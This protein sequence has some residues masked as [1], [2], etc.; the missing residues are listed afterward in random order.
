MN[1]TTTY[2]EHVAGAILDW[3]EVNEKLGQLR[4]T[5]VDLDIAVL[6]ATINR[7]K[8]VSKGNL[9]SGA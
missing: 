9:T 8:N 7:L 6:A 1:Y 3:V 5:G 2:R 4:V